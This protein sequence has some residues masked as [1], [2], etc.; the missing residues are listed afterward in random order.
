[1]TDPTTLGQERPPGSAPGR[2]RH[3][4]GRPVGP[5]PLDPGQARLRRRPASRDEEQRAFD[6]S[7]AAGATLFDTA[8][9][10]GAGAS[11]RRLGELAHGR[12]V[13]IATKFPP[14]M[15]SRADAMPRALE[16]SLELL[17]RTTV[18]LYMHHYPSRWVSIPR[19]MNL[20]ADAVEQGKVRAVGVSNYSADQMRLA[21]AVLAE[22][23]IPLASNQVEYSLL[24]RQPET[25]GVLDACRELGVT[26]IANQPLANGALTGK[27]VDGARPTGFRRFMPRFRG[28]AARGRRLRSS[29]CSARSASAHGRSPAQVALRWLIENELV[30][31]IPGAKNGRQAADNAGALAFSLDPGRD[32]GPRSG[33]RRLA[34][35][36]KG[37]HVVKFGLQIYSFTWPGGP[38]A[39]GP[40]LARAVRT[41]D[42]VGFDSIWVMDHFWQIGGP[43]SELQPMLE[44]WTTLGFM[45]ANSQRARLGLM[46]GGVHYRNPGLWVK[47]ATTLDVLSGGRAWLGIG[48]GLEPGRVGG[49][50]LPVA[51]RS[52]SASRC[53]RTPSRSPTAC[54]RASA[55]RRRTSRVASSTRR[56]LLNVPQSISRPRVP[57]MIGGG[58]EKKT[59]RLVAQYADASNLFGGP[60]QLLPKYA[61]LAEHCAAVGRDFAEI[62]RT[63]MQGVGL[64]SGRCVEPR[65]RVARRDRRAVRPA[66]RGGRPARHRELRRG[67]RPGAD[68]AARQ[69]G[70][71]PAPRRRGGRS[72]AA[73]RRSPEDGSA[74][75]SW[76]ALA[77]AAPELAAFGAERLHDQVAYLAT[78]KPDG[79]PRLHPVRPVV[80]VGRLFVFMEATSPKVHDLERDPRYALHAT[81]TSDQPW[82]LREFGV[83]GTARRVDDP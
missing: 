73:S 13:L 27:F 39:I 22:R 72:A 47:A 59:L 33:H 28:Q 24:H 15:L 70:P 20:M 3:D 10:Y 52:A 76:Q 51:R 79:S 50:R 7:V 16:R 19:L 30:V 12:D 49:S 57:I 36:T 37:H 75:M 25:D 66:R 4:L 44:G 67:E 46:V 48:A 56:R 68:R 61:I 31:P 40:T 81:A 80:T 21:H 5:R 38:E 23:G 35:R 65:A 14:T 64:G 83:E 77:D 9:M 74:P 1:M 32:R 29:P 34:R 53:S 2:R 63:N 82:D 6:A 69:P 8:E 54:G 62:E 42:D 60:D 58:G 55:A 45:A 71:A 18:D 78:L 43:G 26:L 17:Q 41:A 11:E